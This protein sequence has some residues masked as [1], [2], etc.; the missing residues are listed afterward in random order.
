MPR[1]DE[2]EKWTTSAGRMMTDG[3]G[4]KSRSILCDISHKWV[5][6]FDRKTFST[7]LFHSCG[8]S[9]G[10][11]YLRGLGVD[12]YLRGL[13]GLLT[14]TSPPLLLRP[15]LHAATPSRERHR[16][17]SRTSCIGRRSHRIR[18]RAKQH[19][20]WSSPPHRVRLPNEKTLS[21]HFFPS[22]FRSSDVQSARRLTANSLLSP[23]HQATNV[24][25][26]RQA[27]RL[28]AR[29]SGDENARG[30][31]PSSDP[32]STLRLPSGSTPPRSGRVRDAHPSI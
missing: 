26:T 1:R 11:R 15:R 7:N 21:R 20:L 14:T 8:R 30:A 19:H 31:L 32:F 2:D 28:I 27:G 4:V 23:H 12:R 25:E 6:S 16:V 5:K 29:D 13:R 17:A 24:G 3:H 22:D 9:V 10:R 18:V